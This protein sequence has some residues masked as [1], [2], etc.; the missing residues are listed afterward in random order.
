MGLFGITFFIWDELGLHIMTSGLAQSDPHKFALY[1][2][3]WADL[4]WPTNF[5]E[6]KLMKWLLFWQIDPE[7][8]ISILTRNKDN[9]HILLKPLI[10]IEQTLTY[11]ICTPQLGTL[12]WFWLAWVFS[13]P[14]SNSNLCLHLGLSGPLLE[15]VTLSFIPSWSLLIHMKSGKLLP[16]VQIMNFIIKKLN[17]LEF[18]LSQIRFWTNLV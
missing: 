15:L 3:T 8:S 9:T 14:I 16:L 2:R 7:I 17:K 4:F 6:Y 1:D 12:H 11:D 10:E 18:F 5:F 13:L